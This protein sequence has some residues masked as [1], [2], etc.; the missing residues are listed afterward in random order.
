MSANRDAAGVVADWL[1]DCA[2]P[3]RTSTHIDSD[4]LRTC[5]PVEDHP[6]WR[7]QHEPRPRLKR[8]SYEARV[9]RV[10]F[11]G[12][13]F[14]TVRWTNPW[15]PTTALFFGDYFGG[16][17]ADLFGPGGRDVPIRS[18]SR[19]RLTPG[20]AHALDYELIAPYPDQQLARRFYTALKLEQDDREL[21]RRLQT[22]GRRSG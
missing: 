4:D 18:R 9:R 20:H 15:L 14:A 11:H 5:P 2:A 21:S 10:L 1:A 3:R 22:D 13:A 16:P 19:R 17:L 6:S 7:P 12:A 8:F